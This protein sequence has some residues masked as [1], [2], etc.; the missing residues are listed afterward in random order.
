MASNPFDLTGKVAVITG[1]NSGLGFAFASGLARAGADV[2]IWGRRED[3]NRA[4]VDKLRGFGH[5]VGSR[6]VDVAAEQDVV[7]AMQA[8]VGEM[9]RLD[10]VIANAGIS[11]FAPSTAEM[12]SQQYHDLLNINLHGAFYTLREGAKHMVERAKRG[13]PGGSLIICGSLSIFGGVPGMGHYAAAKGAL[14]SLAKTMATELGPYQ[15][16]VNVIAPG[17]FATEMTQADPEIFKAVDAAVAA[18]TP[19]GRTG[20]PEDIEG[21]AVYLASDAARFHSGDTL[22]VDGGRL[23]SGV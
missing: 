21:I 14:N 10:C 8:A 19:M 23:A 20:Q 3:K 18:R 16:R 22:V 9:G 5:R 6:V 11:G 13:E 4:A 17:F 2:L 7:A 12:S 1:A 15:I